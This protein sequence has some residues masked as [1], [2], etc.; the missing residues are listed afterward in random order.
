M[1]DKVIELLFK[2]YSEES[3]EDALT[4]IENQVQLLRREIRGKKNVQDL[5]KTI[6]QLQKKL[7]TEKS[8][9]EAALKDK[10]AALTR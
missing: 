9:K 8:A 4:T 6:D 3:V 1:N 2:Y 10:E 5:Q 7:S